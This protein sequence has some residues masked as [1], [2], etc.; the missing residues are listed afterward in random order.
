MT[1]RVSVVSAEREVWSGDARMVV[2]RTLDG[3]IGILTGHVPTLSVLGAG[4]VR[5]DAESG[6]GL[7]ATVD[8]GFLSVEHDTVLVVAERV[9]LGAGTGDRGAGGSPS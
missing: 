8:G 5:V 1:L 9:S 4:E 3:E 2:A 6:E 7:V